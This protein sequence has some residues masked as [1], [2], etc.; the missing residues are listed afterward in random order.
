MCVWGCVPAE[1]HNHQK[2]K[3]KSFRA[4][5]DEVE[6]GR[7]HVRTRHVQPYASHIIVNRKKEKQKLY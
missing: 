2:R 5:D 6:T 4:S 1:V 7:G 3:K